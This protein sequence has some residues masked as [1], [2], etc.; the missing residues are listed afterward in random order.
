M[1]TT[2]RSV[3]PPLFLDAEVIQN[4]KQTLSQGHLADAH[5]AITLRAWVVNCG[6]GL[7]A[8][9]VGMLLSDVLTTVAVPARIQVFATAAEESTL[10][11]ARIGRFPTAAMASLPQRFLLTYCTEVERDG[12][13]E[14]IIKKELRERIVFSVHDILRDPPLSNLDLIVG[15]SSLCYLDTGASAAVQMKFHFALRDGGILCLGKDDTVDV[16]SSL[17]RRLD[18]LY[19]IYRAKKPTRARGNQ[20][21]IQVP[22][23]SLPLGEYATGIR[24][25]HEGIAFTDAANKYNAASEQAMLSGSLPAN[26]LI[27]SDFSIIHV[28][29]N[30]VQFLAPA[31]GNPTT[32]LISLIHASLQTDL[33]ACLFKAASLHKTV[34][35]CNREF[36]TGEWVTNVHMTVRPVASGNKEYMLVGFDIIDASLDRQEGT[37][38]IET[39]NTQLEEDNARLSMQLRRTIEEAQIALLELRTANEEAQSANEEIRSIAE[40]FEASKEELQSLNEELVTIND[41]VLSKATEAATVNEDLTNFIAASNIPIIFI[42]DG[43]LI[44][45]FTP[46]AKTIFSFESSDIG[47]SI[48]DIRHKLD[49]TGFEND[50]RAVT[51]T[52]IPVEREVIHLDGRR[53]SVR[54]S[55]FEKTGG[56]PSGAVITFNDVTGLRQAEA[57]VLATEARMDLLART[58]KDYAIVSLDPNGKILSWNVGAERTF[59]YSACEAVGKRG[60]VIFAMDEAGKRAFE[61]EMR[62]ALIEGRSEDERWHRRKTGERIYCSGILIA[63]YADNGKFEGFAKIARD[64]TKQERLIRLRAKRLSREREERI[65][66]EQ[67]N[68]LK[69]RFLAIMSHE[70]KHPLNLISV[71]AEL[72]GRLP[73]AHADGMTGRALNNITRAVSSQAKI[74]DDLLD[75]SRLNTGKLRLDVAPVD[76]SA[77]T[78]SIV[79]AAQEVAAIKAIRLSLETDSTPIVTSADQVRFEQILWNLISNS[80][81]FTPSGGSVRVSLRRET[82]ECVLHVTDSG[83]GMD[84]AS[85]SQAFDLFAQA[86]ATISPRVGGLGIGLA[87]VK[88]LVHAHG[89]RVKASSPGIGHGVTISVWLPVRSAVQTELPP[90]ESVESTLAGV[91]VLIID[92]AIDAAEALGALLE[93][94]GALPT[95]VGSGEEAIE[96][97]KH[98][99]FDILVSDVAMPGMDG[100]ELMSRIRTGFRG[101]DLPAVALSGFGSDTEREKSREA[102]FDCH[103]QKPVS[104]AAL[105]TALAET[106]V[107]RR[108]GT[109]RN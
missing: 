84:A 41:E 12:R 86:E 25:S 64:V 49:W 40:E 52:S 37:T 106:L 107:H 75:L 72:L 11:L 76:L 34:G 93:T 71:N 30:A 32:N 101:R 5:T 96:T 27:D 39:I 55:R 88:E 87:L 42:D 62:T 80:L 70:L 91:S 95:I 1:L 90:H 105:Q 53:L 83:V 65:A 74:I 19:N 77:C 94:T 23:F 38:S 50:L 108:S 28:S 16:G 2:H 31:A 59:G 98:R 104:L 3:S 9:A 35:V 29:A 21:A 44:R 99:D 60:S 22:D 15:A 97:L 54:L 81:K 26:I 17:F 46:Q 63:L 78:H 82:G 45:R 89:G 66:S 51:I 85:L 61:T 79:N 73:L 69:D 102:G 58:T 33:R 109:S 10:K 100:Y 57:T 56:M 18:G 6:T 13:R 20:S 24:S 103:L 7:D 48:L 47:R 43:L 14:F 92:D 8:Y 67:A 4:L 36:P 68:R